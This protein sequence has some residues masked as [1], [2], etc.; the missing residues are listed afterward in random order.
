[1]LAKKGVKRPA[2]PIR[3]KDQYSLMQ[4]ER[5]HPEAQPIGLGKLE[6]GQRLAKSFCLWVDQDDVTLAV[7]IALSISI[8]LIKIRLAQPLPVR[9][10]A[11]LLD[12]QQLP[13]RI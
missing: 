6:H 5:Q 13:F 11:L 2:S 10:I 3:R 7:Y 4:T 9:S 8:K 1:M 12:F